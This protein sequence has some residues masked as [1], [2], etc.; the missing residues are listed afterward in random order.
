M[1]IALIYDHHEMQKVIKNS[2][3]W[4]KI[5]LDV[6]YFM[7]SRIAIIIWTDTKSDYD[8]LNKKLENKETFNTII[9][10]KLFENYIKL[11]YLNQIH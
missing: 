7:N 1:Q 11:N 3:N 2:L 6:F 5:I 8:H 4:N 10:W 9:N